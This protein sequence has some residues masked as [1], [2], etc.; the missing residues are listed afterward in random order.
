MPLD[1]LAATTVADLVNRRVPVRKLI[2]LAPATVMS[3][4]WWASEDLQGALVDVIH[5]R[6]MQP[7]R[8]ACTWRST[9]SCSQ[10]GSRAALTGGR[11]AA[12][13]VSVVFWRFS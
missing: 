6:A 4:A 3:V 2:L 12:T 1:L 5:G 10:S 9:S 13:I 7:Q 11:G 8:W